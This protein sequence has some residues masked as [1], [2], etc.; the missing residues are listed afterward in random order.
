MIQ[1]IETR[2][3]PSNSWTFS[4]SN[5]VIRAIVLH[6]NSNDPNVGQNSGLNTVLNPANNVSYHYIIR[7]DGHITNTVPPQHIAHAAGTRTDRGNMDAIHSPHEW[8]R[9]LRTQNANNWTIN[10][11]FEQMPRGNPSSEQLNSASELIKYLRTLYT[12]PL[13][14]IIGHI[15]IV[16]RHRPLCPGVGFP[17]ERLR[18][19]IRERE[20]EMSEER[21]RELV[22]RI[23]DE[24]QANINTLQVSTPHAANWEQSTSRGIMDGTRP[25]ATVT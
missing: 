18:N 11:C 14:R 20:E 13:E 7:R 22:N 10:I 2:T 19:M 17:Y 9:N 24:R 25:Q 1:N 5:R 4:N 12:I 16:P 6:T 21:I 23:L 8:I 15:D 3:A